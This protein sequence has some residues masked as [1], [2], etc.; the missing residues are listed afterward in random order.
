MTGGCYC[1]AIRYAVTADPVLRAQCHCRPCQYF[2]GGGPNYFMIVP[3]DG[4]AYSKGTPAQFARTDLD[5]PRTRDFCPA[6]GT[7]LLT[8]RSNGDAIV[9]VGTLDDPATFGSPVMAINCA[10]MQDFHVIPEGLPRFDG[11]PG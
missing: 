4:F 3:A 1:G 9:K 10:G 2:S 7:H 11:L 6:C 8:R 5:N